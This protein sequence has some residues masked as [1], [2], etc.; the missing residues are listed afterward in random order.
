MKNETNINIGALPIAR[1]E[2]Q[3]QL[4]NLLQPLITK[5]F[6]S[7]FGDAD[8]FCKKENKPE[9]LYMTF[10]KFVKKIRTWSSIIVESETERIKNKIHC[11]NELITIIFVGNVKIL[12]SIRLKGKH[13][14]LKIKVPSCEKFI[15]TVYINTAKRVFYDPYIF[16]NNIDPIKKEKNMNRM[17]GFIEKAISD[18]ISQM[19][20]I[21]S[22]LD[23]YLG[24]AFD[25]EI[26]ES[27]S[28]SDSESNKSEQ[29][30]YGDEIESSD[31]EEQK[32]TPPKINAPSINFKNNIPTHEN[33]YAKETPT[34]TYAKET[35]TNTYAKETPTNTYAKETPTNTY[36]KET[37]TN[38]YD[39]SEE[40]S[41]EESED[42]K[43]IK[44][45]NESGEESGEESEDTKKIKSDNESGEE[46]GEESEEESGEESEND[47][48]EEDEGP[49]KNVGPEITKN[50]VRPDIKRSDYQ[51]PLLKFNNNKKFSRK[52]LER[53]KFFMNRAHNTQ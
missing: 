22:I 29:S 10:Q 16:E 44:S 48:S 5:G 43:K 52:F 39:E 32:H 40:E 49:P 47:E 25:E 9:E 50:Y 42:T 11:L 33:I 30:L 20:P 18:T 41:G 8:N 45:D 3:N 35:P 31:E 27:E 23:E 4:T 34:N 37:P 24:N 12:A 17:Y 51:K 38:I 6:W 15:H 7:I 36:A 13:A 46:S 53:P 2:Y 28:E 1:N 26:E 19:L 14:N 21:E